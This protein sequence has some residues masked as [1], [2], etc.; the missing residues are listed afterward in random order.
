VLG[1]FVIEATQDAD[2]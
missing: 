1:L 2:S